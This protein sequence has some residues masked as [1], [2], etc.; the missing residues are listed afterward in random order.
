MICFQGLSATTLFASKHDHR[1]SSSIRFVIAR[2]KSQSNCYFKFLPAI[3]LFCPLFHV[4]ARCFNKNSKKISQSDLGNN[5]YMACN[6]VLY[7]LLIRFLTSRNSDGT[8]TLNLLNVSILHL[9]SYVI[10][11]L[12]VCRVC[13]PE[14]LVSLLIQGIYSS[15]NPGHL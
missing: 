3:S 7:D 12:R 8:T 13:L 5:A 14:I 6:Y 9:T 1:M 11:S 2:R 10:W 4:F 15:L